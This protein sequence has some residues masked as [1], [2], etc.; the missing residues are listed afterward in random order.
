MY[1][2]E[3]D[4]Q[5]I[6]DDW[7]VASFIFANLWTS[8]CKHAKKELGQYSSILTTCLVNNLTCMYYAC[9]CIF[10]RKTFIVCTRMYSV[11]IDHS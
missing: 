1:L 4:L 3:L 6:K 2:E 5:L 11:G 9:T 10:V 8:G 7:I